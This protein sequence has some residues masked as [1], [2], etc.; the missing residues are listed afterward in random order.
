MGDGVLSPGSMLG[1]PS[2]PS[3]DLDYIMDELFL[4]G[5]WLETTDGL[6]FL[7]QSPSNSTAL[8]DPSCVWPT[9][10][11]DGDLCMSPSQKGNQEERQSPLLN[12]SQE[13]PFDKQLVSQNMINMPGSSSSHSEIGLRR[14]WIG[15]TA[16][17]GPASSVMERL[18]RALLHI[19]NFVSDKDVLVQIWVP[20]NKGGRNVLTTNDLPFSLDSNCKRLAKYRDISVKYQ[21]SAEEDSKEVVVGLPSRVFSGKVPE[22]TPDVRFFRSDEYPRV[23][24]A[25]QYDVRGTLA[26]PVFEQGNRTC[27]GVIE[28]VMTTRR[29]KYLPELENVCKALEAFDLRSSEVLSTQNVKVHNKSYQAALPEI[30]EVLRSACETHKLPLAQTWVSCAQ[31][32]KDGCRHS[33]MNYFQ[34][35]STV[36]HA[37]Y[38][39]EPLIQG[40]HEACSEHHL[41]KGQG[42]VGGAFLINQPCF[43]P[44]ITSLG[45]TEYPLSHH[46]RMFGLQAAAAIRLRS[47]HTN[48]DDFVL[49]FFLPIDCTDPEEQKKTLTSL[50]LIIQR[51]C[52][53]LRVIT[54]KELEE[55]T[56]LSV[57]EDISSR[58]A[59]STEF[60]E[61]GTVGSLIAKE[62]SNDMMGGKFSDPRQNDE[63]SNLKGSA[64]YVGE[65]STVGEGSFSSAGA[66]KTG[67]KRR[68]KAEKTIT[69]EVLRQHFAGS[70]KDAAR[71]LGV[72]TTTLKR[73]CRQHGVK[74]WPSRKIKKS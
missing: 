25:Q 19:K 30:Q 8:L 13:T 52:H 15:P 6:E 10:E 70:L 3:M 47:I 54:A 46:A 66:S 37:C 64:K 31:Q 35:V 23:D 62:K 5:C 55:E 73:I 61:S 41:L 21:F 9:L 7:C 42:V 58:T 11:I 67:E 17:P 53:N 27:L 44:D 38:V 69:L 74:R 72:C 28:V 45:K 71:N 65:F 50:S 63:D 16:Y 26:L 68:T 56:C 4:D 24:H 34:C 12:E 51:V 49:E 40:F 43:S 48:T 36:D 39:G 57:V 20:L 1:E 33:D 22:W 18:L 14:W 59:C 29:I 60:Q 32:G 2:G